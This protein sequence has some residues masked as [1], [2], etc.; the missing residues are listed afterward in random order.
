MTFGRTAR[1]IHLIG[2]IYTRFSEDDG[3][4]IASHMAMSALMALFPFLIFVTA[5]G[6]IMGTPEPA[7]RDRH[8]PVRI[9][10][11]RDRRADRRGGLE[12]PVPVPPRPPDHRR[13]ARLHSRHQRR[14][15]GADRH[16]PGLSRPRGARLLAVPA[17][18]HALRHRRRHG[19]G[20]AGGVR[21]PVARAVA[22]GGALGAALGGTGV[23]RRG[24]ALCDR[25]PDPGR[26][27]PT[28]PPLSRRRPPQPAR[29]APGRRFDLRA[30]ARQRRRLRGLFH[31][32]QRLHARPMPASPA[33]SPRCSSSGWSRSCS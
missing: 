3:W 22:D 32:L 28:G 17:A 24:A 18:G 7:G 30:V 26:R 5:L 20:G 10:A 19:A 13:G 1:V 4:A 12:G 29:R 27:H 6:A 15:G 21:R 33:S 25:L 8:A 14:R 23:H 31:R 9:L 2:E 11:A 16:Q